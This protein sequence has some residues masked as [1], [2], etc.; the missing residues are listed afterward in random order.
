MVITKN[1]YIYIY[2]YK[3]HKYNIIGNPS[4][5]INDIKRD[6]TTSPN[7]QAKNKKQLTQHNKQMR[8]RVRRCQ[9]LL[10]R[11]DRNRVHVLHP[12][13]HSSQL[14]GENLAT[15]HGVNERRALVRRGDLHERR[16]L[17]RDAVQR[18][19]FRGVRRQV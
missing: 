13:N 17:D 16:V 6:G 7:A 15:L 2:I 19:Q 8:D 1:L 18:R 14:S 9:E 3:T 10:D 11:L 4:E 5:E 12:Q